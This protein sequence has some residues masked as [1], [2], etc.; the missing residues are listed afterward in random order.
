MD[1][2]LLKNAKN[3][4]FCRANI[5]FITL[6]TLQL[7]LS[8]NTDTIHLRRKNVKNASFR[9]AEMPIWGAG[10]IFVLKLHAH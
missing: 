8:W 7:G 3:A 4:I 2:I 10:L 5:L 1:R 6:E 9:V